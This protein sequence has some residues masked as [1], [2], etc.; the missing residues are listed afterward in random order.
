MEFLAFILIAFFA[1]A[2]AIALDSKAEQ[3]NPPKPSPILTSSRPVDQYPTPE[4][5]ARKKQEIIDRQNKRIERL[6]ETA[7]P[8]L[9]AFLNRGCTYITHE[10]LWG[11]ICGGGEQDEA[12]R[13]LIRECK[14]RGI[15][16]TITDPRYGYCD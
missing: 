5:I 15:S 12:A 13:C 11:S 10:E 3:G 7:R 4:H 1:V 6:V 2:I 16:V 9:I 8:K 14:V